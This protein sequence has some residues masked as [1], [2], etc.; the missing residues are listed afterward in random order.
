[1]SRAAGVDDVEVFRAVVDTFRPGDPEAD[2]L[3]H[4]EDRHG[5]AVFGPYRTVGAARAAATRESR[6]SSWDRDRYGTTAA[7]RVERAS[8][9]W[10]PV[11]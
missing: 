8:L 10:Q 4:R 6:V 3:P 11:E 5:T 7:G 2:Y 1:V 9:D